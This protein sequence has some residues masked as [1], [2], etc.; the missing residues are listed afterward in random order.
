MYNLFRELP[1]VSSH[2]FLSV[3][4]HSRATLLEEIHLPDSCHLAPS[5]ICALVAEV[6]RQGGNPHFHVLPRL[7]TMVRGKFPREI[8]AFCRR[9]LPYRGTHQAVGCTPIV[10]FYQDLI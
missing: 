1:C 2:I 4:F 10:L 3:S 8:K 6:Q 9:S 5:M 7:S